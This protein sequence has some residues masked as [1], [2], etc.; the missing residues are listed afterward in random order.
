MS[1]FYK[2]EL[3]RLSRLVMAGRHFQCE[4]S[5]VTRA[6]DGPVRKLPR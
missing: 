6:V 3:G 4:L 2:D 1:F 5:K